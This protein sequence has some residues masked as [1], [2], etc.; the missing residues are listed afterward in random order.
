MFNSAIGFA[1]YLPT[2]SREN[3]TGDGNVRF[4]PRASVAGDIAMFSYAG[5]LGLNYRPLTETDALGTELTIA[6][7]AGVRV[8]EKKQLLLGPEIYGST[9]ADSFGDKRATPLE[10][11][12][13]GHYTHG[14]FRFGA[15]TGTGLTRGWGTPILRTVL[16]AEWTP[17]VDKDSDGDHI[18]DREDACPTVPGVRTTNPR[19]NGCPLPAEPP[20]ET[21][22]ATASPTSRTRVPTFR[23]SRTSTRRRTAARRSRRRRIFDKDDACPDVPGVRTTT[24]RRTAA[25]PTRDGDGI[26]DDEDACPDVPGVKDATTRRRTAARPIATATASSTRSTR[27]RMRRARP[28]RIRRRTA[29]RSLVSRAVRSRS[30]SR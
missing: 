9:V 21:A 27:A 5:R 6:A 30:S 3:F 29:A 18:F 11:L 14:D 13:G 8:L 15:G 4:S 12:V 1:L 16:S 17:G 23:A 19:T 22:T 7:S 26:I 2:G 28:I 24:R 25:R 10:W 20:E